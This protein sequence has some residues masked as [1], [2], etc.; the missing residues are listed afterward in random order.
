MTP[1]NPAG[2]PKNVNPGQVVP[3]GQ[4]A[5]PAPPPQP[6]PPL[7][8]D[9]NQSNNFMDPGGM[10]RTALLSK[11]SCL[12]TSIQDFPL[13]FANP[14]QT[15]NVLNDFD[16]DSFLQDGN[17]EADHFDF[18]SGFTMEGDTGIGATD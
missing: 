1:V 9:P 14:M 11:L 7:H 15:E 5:A 10:V 17:P 4:P 6:A 13:D 18:G 16:F 3:N 12:L 8:A 2:F